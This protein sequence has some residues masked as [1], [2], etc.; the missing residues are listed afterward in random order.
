MASVPFSPG[1]PRGKFVDA[2]VSLLERLAFIFPHF[3]SLLFFRFRF[4]QGE[5]SPKNIVGVVCV[6]L[7]LLCSK[8]F[9]PHTSV[10]EGSREAPWR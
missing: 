2:G 9:P 6:I 7:P 5:F 10:K 4:P 1:R 3:F 8:N